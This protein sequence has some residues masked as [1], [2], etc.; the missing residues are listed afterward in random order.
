MKDESQIIKERGAHFTPDYIAEFIVETTYGL[1]ISAHDRISVLDPSCGDGELLVAAV[2]YLKNKGLCVDVYGVET[3]EPTLSL[4][5]RRIEPLLD[6]CDTCNLYQADFLSCQSEDDEQRLLDGQNEMPLIPK[7]DMLI[8]NPPYVRTQVLGAEVAQHL[9]R[10]YKLSGK[11]DLYHAFFLNYIHFLKRDGALG[12]ITSNRYLYTK[13]GDQ[14][15][16]HLHESYCID[17]IFDLGDTKVFSAAVLPA[18]LFARPGNNDSHKTDCARIYEHFGDSRPCEDAD[19]VD[20]LKRGKSGIYRLSERTFE[21]DFG[22][23]RNTSFSKDPWILASEKQE[24]WLDAVEHASKSRIGELAKVRVGIKT[25]AD[26]VFIKE[27]WGIEQEP[28]PEAEW[29][30]PLISSDDATAWKLGICPK[31]TILYPHYTTESGKRAVADLSKYPKMK[32]YLDSHYEQ[33]AGRSYVAKAGR[34]WYEIWVPQD[35][36]AWKNPKVVFPDISSNARFFID[37]DGFLVD[38]NCYWILPNR[39]DDIDLLYA[40][41]GVANSSLM[42]SYHSLAF[43]NVLYSGKRRYLTQYVSNYPLPD[44]ESKSCQKL[45]SYLRETIP[46]SE[47]VDTGYVDELVYEAFGV[48]PF[49]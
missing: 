49:E 5:R 19:L 30:F 2:R 1:I 14:V 11:T 18:L 20:L 42:D 25:T 29:L 43:Q 10:K 23:V 6:E 3:D 37:V 31:R 35:P 41:L 36:S 47:S 24:A 46:S 45:I 9:S 34:K 33:L 15:R 40:I 12:V 28:L 4:A 8:A 16:K 21:L 48:D 17:A 44:L 32:A 7:V 13:S 39:S 26:N 38:G 22:H 27:K